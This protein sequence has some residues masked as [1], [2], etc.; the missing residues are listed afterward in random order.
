VLLLDPDDRVLLLGYDDGRGRYWALPGGGLE[1]GETH[2]QAAVREVAEEVGMVIELGPE[3]WTAE[4]A[5][6]HSVGAVVQHE[7]VWLARVGAAQ[8]AAAARADLAVSH[9]ADDIRGHRW[10]DA[11]TLADCRER[12]T[13]PQ[14]PALAAAVLRAGGARPAGWPVALGLVAL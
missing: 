12:F 3:L 6:V 4:R 5:I 1:P 2:A 9:A 10:F 7:R 13:P 11:R 8:L 14:L